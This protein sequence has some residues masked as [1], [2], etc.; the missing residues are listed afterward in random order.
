VPD[1]GQV[2]RPAGSPPGAVGE[3][4][5]H[6][7]AT[8]VADCKGSASDRPTVLVAWGEAHGRTW[9]IEAAPPRP[10]EAGFCW[11]NGLFSADG[12][13]GVGGNGALPV[14]SLQASGSDNIRIGNEYWGF[15][16]GPVTKRAARLQV[17]FD[18]G[19]PPLNLT[20]IQSGDR[21][22]V[23]FYAGFYHQPAKDKRP[24]TWQVIRVVAYDQGNQK[25]AECQAKGGTGHSC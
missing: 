9:L 7:V 6:D 25:V 24:A 12:E 1:P 2:E 20:P 10:G 11:A 18:M 21:F 22:P 17:Q 16:V 14:T 23:N 4:M 19:I 5:V 13:G 3:Q 15:V 8:V